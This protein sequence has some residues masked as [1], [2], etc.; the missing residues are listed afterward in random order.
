MKSILQE[1]LGESSDVFRLVEQEPPPSL[2]KGVARI[3]MEYVAIHPGDLLAAAG[4]PAFSTDPVS[5]PVSGRIPGLEGVGVI[6]GLAGGADPG[7]GLA[8]GQRVVLFPVSGTWSERV[9]APVMSLLPL[10]D[11]IPTTIAASMLIDAIA[12]SM[13]VRVG[14]GYLSSGDAVLQTAAG[15]AVARLTTILLLERGYAPIR[16]TRTANGAA[17]LQ[18]RLPGPPVFATEQADWIRKVA[19]AVGGRSVPVALDGVGGAL[20]ASVARCVDVGGTI[21]SYGALGGATA[22]IR[23]FV[24]RSLTVRGVTIG[25]WGR[26]TPAR[27][28]ADVETA[29]RLARSH[30]EQFEPIGIYRP[31]QVALA[32]E[33][34]RRP[35][36]LGSVLLDF[37]AVGA[38]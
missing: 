30:P 1:R 25:T 28:A 11:D 26:E 24:P 22:D 31:E 38:G 20:L 2:S 14:E 3:R 37:R 13:I 7:L 12:A 21:V 15:S 18:S 5:I 16:L 35:G 19:S 4:S 6:E 34:S 36:K 33:H 32:I 29:I 17:A 23:L 8:V 27:R 9:V 10:P